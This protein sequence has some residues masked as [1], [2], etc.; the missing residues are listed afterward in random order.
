MPKKRDLKSFLFS[1]C[2]MK[3]TLLIHLKYIVEHKKEKTNEDGKINRRIKAYEKKINDQ[4]VN[5][6]VS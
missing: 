3:E 5:Y 6:Q 4:Q 1:F 2:Q